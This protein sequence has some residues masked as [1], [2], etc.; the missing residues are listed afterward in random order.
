MKRFRM[1]PLVSALAAVLLSAGFA[2]A[3]IPDDS[4]VYHGCF[5]RGAPLRVIDPAR[6]SCRPGERVISWSERGPVGPAGPVG[7]QG[8]TGAQ[9]PVGPE[10]PVGPQGPEGPEGPMGP[11]GGGLESFDQLAGL[12]CRVGEPEEGITVIGYDSAT[13]DLS[14]KCDPSNL[15]ELTVVFGGGGPGRVVSEPAGID[16]PDDCTHTGV[17]NDSV[18]LTA[19]DTPD[20]IFAGWSGACTGTG[21]CTVTLDGDKE[22]TATFTPAFML[23]A[24]VA[25]EAVLQLCPPLQPLCTPR[26]NATLSFGTLVVDFVGVCELAPGLDLTTTRWHVKACQWKV[27]DGTYIFAAASGS[28]EVLTWAGDCAFASNECDLGPRSTPTSVIVEFSWPD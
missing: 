16:C 1:A 17:S 8:A 4:G 22:V 13:R 19:T 26:Y 9:G 27:P 20:S 24:E 25:A 2:S 18:T 11:S 10:G 12:P 15:S 3:A 21:T 14:L 5:A 28:P 6:E 7:P 23:T